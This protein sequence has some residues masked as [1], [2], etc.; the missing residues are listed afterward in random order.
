MATPTP[1][2]SSRRA[3]ANPTTPLSVSK[4]QNGIND[5][6]THT[7][8]QSQNHT[9]GRNQ[10]ASDYESSKIALSFREVC[11]MLEKSVLDFRIGAV[12]L[13]QRLAPAV[14][15]LSS[16]SSS[17]SQTEDSVR[18]PSKQ[19]RRVLKKS[20]ESAVSDPDVS[21]Q[22]SF[23]GSLVDF[24][25]EK[26]SLLHRY[27]AEDVLHR[28]AYRH[29]LQ[30]SQEN[31]Q[32]ATAI[33]HH[34]RKLDAELASRVQGY[35]EGN[36]TISSNQEARDL[37][38]GAQID[39]LLRE[40]IAEAQDRVYRL[41]LDVQRYSL[42]QRRVEQSLVLSGSQRGAGISDEGD[43]LP[44]EQLV[45]TMHLRDSLALEALGLSRSVSALE[46]EYS[47]LVS[48]QNQLARDNMQFA[49]TI[50][51][52]KRLSQPSLSASSN[53]SSSSASVTE[54]EYIRI[55]R[56]R[57]TIL[58]SVLRALVVESGIDWY[59]DP[60]LRDAMLKQ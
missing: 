43:S 34:R 38:I 8:G 44:Q 50:Q 24:D 36:Q 40:R 21:A 5:H 2:K 39:E 60:A 25:L 4:Q 6:H 13:L 35:D 37:K 16:A 20:L 31:M 45:N 3:A 49:R 55:L 18:T 59:A 11:D 7:H 33:S 41:S 30:R 17:T 42:L 29:W 51:E 56:E 53:A 54:A 19:S 9:H 23:D 27:S 57:N 32:S 26:R 46:D 1:R 10:S 22:S 48:L 14:R 15:S 12:P 28:S 52:L 47:A 58:R